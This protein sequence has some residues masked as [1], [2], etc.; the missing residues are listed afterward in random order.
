MKLYRG[1]WELVY[2]LDPAG[3][4]MDGPRALLAERAWSTRNRPHNGW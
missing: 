2:R 4:H 3:G 1:H